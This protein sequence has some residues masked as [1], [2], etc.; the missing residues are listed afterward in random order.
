MLPQAD[1]GAKANLCIGYYT[2]A[3]LSD[4]CRME[5]NDVDL[6]QGT[7]TYVQRKTGSR[8]PKLCGL[9]RDTFTPRGLIYVRMLFRVWQSKLPRWNS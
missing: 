9:V 3:R 5:W 1:S 7:L 6:A 2:G 4:C 8:L